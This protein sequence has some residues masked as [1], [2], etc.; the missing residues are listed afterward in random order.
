MKKRIIFLLLLLVST[1]LAAQDAVHL[2]GTVTD[3][4]SGE[5]LI[6]VSVYVEGTRTGVSTDANGFYELD[7][8]AG[9]TINYMYLGYKPKSVRLSGQTVL[10]VALEVDTQMLDE[11]VVVGYSVQREGM[12]SGLSARLTATN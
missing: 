5:T 10:D 1:G 6:G 8:P 4:A 3:A 9:A 2:K 12:C 7:V 11:S